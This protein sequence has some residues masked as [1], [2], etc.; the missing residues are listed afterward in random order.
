MRLTFNNHGLRSCLARAKALLA[1]EHVFFQKAL[2]VRLRYR[3]EWELKVGTCLGQST[4]P[5]SAR[6]ERE[7]GETLST[8]ACRRTSCPTL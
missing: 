5:N 7:R 4:E 2:A 6:L 8:Q 3:K 1:R